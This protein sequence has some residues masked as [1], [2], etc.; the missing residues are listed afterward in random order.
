MKTLKRI[1]FL[2]VSVILLMS[3]IVNAQDIKKSKNDGEVTFSVYIDCP[4][5]LKKLEARLPHEKGVKD[6]NVNFEGQ[7]VWFLYNKQRT[8]KENLQKALE[9]LGY[10]AKEVKPID[11]K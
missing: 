10:P 4:S 3:G 2:L 7:T 11:K 9:K 1:P 6:F 8:N 5:C